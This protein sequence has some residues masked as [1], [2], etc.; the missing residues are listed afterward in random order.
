MKYNVLQPFLAFGKAPAAGDVI[1]LTPEQAEALKFENLISPYEVKVM[2]KPE[3][4]RAPKRSRSAPVGRVLRK[5][6]AKRS[7]KTAKK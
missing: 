1:E 7:K 5:K 2:P 6:T 4:K 3:N